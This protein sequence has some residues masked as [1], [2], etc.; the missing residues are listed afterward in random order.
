VKDKIVKA[1]LVLLIGII[2]TAGMFGCSQSTTTTTTTTSPIPSTTTTA[3]SS[4][5]ELNVSAAA[6]LTDTLKA[7][8]KLY[9][10]ENKTVI[11]VANFAS[12]G[13]L[14]KQIEQGAPVDVFISAA[15]KQMDALQT[16]DLIVN[17]TRRDLLN[18][19]IVLVVPGESRL[20]INDFMDLLNDDV[21]QIA[22]GDPEFVPSGIY[23]KLAF[24]EFGIYEKIQAKLILGIDTPH[25]LG[26]IESGNVDAG[27]IYS[28][29]AAIADKVKVVADAP[30]EVNKKIV[31]PAAVIKASK[32]IEAARAY[33]AFLFSSEAKA[34]F[35]KYGFVVVN[36]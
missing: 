24:K 6:S 14:Q 3:A 4:P 27:I 8:N 31:Y 25:V 33:I 28:T 12:S 20:Q 13:I 1:I 23:G 15:A 7:I 5:V 30:D 17:D 2:L 32:N 11:I 10:E 19:K 21:K 16:G 36:K 26:Y 22:I 9:V 34:V 18:N 35:E 29:D